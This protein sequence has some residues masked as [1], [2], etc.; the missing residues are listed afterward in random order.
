M[1]GSIVILPS[2][3]VSFCAIRLSA[4]EVVLLWRW[5][6]LDTTNEIVQILKN[7]YPEGNLQKQIFWY[8]GAP[9]FDQVIIIDE[10]SIPTAATKIK[11]SEGHLEWMRILDDWSWS[12]TIRTQAKISESALREWLKT[13]LEIFPVSRPIE[14]WGLPLMQIDPISKSDK[15]H[16]TNRNRRSAQ[17]NNL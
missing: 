12:K 8:N 13:M 5:V 2:N 3:R 9:Y 1:R 10:S 15:W 16:V 17:K 14:F 4:R 6:E 11:G 7:P